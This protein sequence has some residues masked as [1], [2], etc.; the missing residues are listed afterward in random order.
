V[1]S[2]YTNIALDTGIDVIVNIHTYYVLIHF[3]ITDDE[4]VKYKMNYA[5]LERWLSS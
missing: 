2:R 1:H 5:G 4:H 3:S